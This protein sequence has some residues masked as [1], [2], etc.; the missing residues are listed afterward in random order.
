[1][2]CFLPENAGNYV[3]GEAALMLD[4]FT[5]TVSDTPDGAVI[6]DYDGR[7]AELSALLAPFQGA[8]SGLSKRNCQKI[9]SINDYILKKRAEMRKNL[10]RGKEPAESQFAGLLALIEEPLTAANASAGGRRKK[11]AEPVE[12]KPQNR[13]GRAPSPDPDEEEDDGDDNTPILPVPEA[14]DPIDRESRRYLAVCDYFRVK[15]GTI[16][17]TVEAVSE[18]LLNTPGFIEKEWLDDSCPTAKWRAEL[19]K[20]LRKTAE[21]FQ[22][23]NRTGGSQV[24]SL[25]AIYLKTLDLDAVIAHKHLTEKLSALPKNDFIRTDRGMLAGYKVFRVVGTRHEMARLKEYLRLARIPTDILEDGM[26]PEPDEL[27]AP[28]FDSFLAMDAEMTGSFGEASGDKPS[29][30]TELSAVRVEHGKIVSTFSELCNP[31]RRIDPRVVKLNGITDAMVAAKPPVKDVMA[32]FMKYMGNMPLVGHGIFDSDLRYLYRA[33][34]RVG[35]PLVLTCFDTYRYAVRVG[36]RYDW[37]RLGLGF[38]ADKLGIPHLDA[39]RALS[40]AVTNAGVYMAMRRLEEDR[41]FVIG[42]FTDARFRADTGSADADSPDTGVCTAE[43]LRALFEKMQDCDI[44][45]SLGNLIER[46][47]DEKTDRATLKAAQEIIDAGRVYVGQRVYHVIGEEDAFA[48]PRDA[49]ALGGVCR[50]IE[51]GKHVLITL[52]ANFYSDGTPYSSVDPDPN[53]AYFPPQELEWLEAQLSVAESAVILC[54]RRLDNNEISNAVDVRRVLRQSGKVRMV[55]QGGSDA[56]GARRKFGGIEYL[57]LPALGVSEE[58]P[59][60]AIEAGDELVV[61]KSF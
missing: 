17:G 21:D 61:R 3:V 15:V 25:K 23:I 7:T 44:V 24:A 19:L 26:P 51:V 11:P 48:L 29:E 38:I 56:V 37:Q 31:G 9:N 13:R 34:G 10:G 12:A 28:T 14:P 39:H 8:E 36:K 32:R 18:L 41:P 2:Y 33:A 46:A 1:M 4:E 60:L 16:G 45:V 59:I 57:T 42:V 40:D 47:G 22:I 35:E 49:F 54:H 53:D 5:L 58:L 43:K 52:D 6:E 30:I 20:K 55:L 27:T 50:C